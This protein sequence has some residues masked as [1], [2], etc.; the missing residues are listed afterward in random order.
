MKNNLLRSAVIY[1][2]IISLISCDNSDSLEKDPRFVHLDSS[3]KKLLTENFSKDSALL[4]FLTGFNEIQENLDQIREKQKIIKVNSTDAE[5]QQN[6]KDQIIEEIKSINDLLDKNKKQIGFVQSKLKNANLKISS[7]E[8][9]IERL[10]GQVAEK[11]AE[12]VSLKEELGRVNNELKGLMAEYSNRVIE[13]DEKT[14]QLNTAYY[15]FGNSK[16]L[17][18]HGVITKEGGFIGIGKTEKLMKD[19]N[20]TYFTKIDISDTREIPLACKKAKLITSHAS[21]SYQLTGTGK[22][23]K[24]VISNPEEF[25][26][27]SKYLVILV[28]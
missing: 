21:G 28:E 4:S 7:L 2:A 27:A 22:I 23:E 25:W 15:A 24:L 6:Q 20:K 3:N 12:I 5:L 26:S 19:F 9:M 17:R 1:L 8:K 13:S 18:D 10:S 16:E 11:D 14:N